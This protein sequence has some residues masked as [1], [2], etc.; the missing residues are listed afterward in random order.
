MNIKT[1]IVNNVGMQGYIMIET[2][3]FFILV[4]TIIVIC[5]LIF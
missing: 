2:T 3:T 5:T 4:T 1:K